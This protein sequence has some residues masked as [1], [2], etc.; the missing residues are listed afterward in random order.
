ML[1]T[2]YQ[3]VL[4]E[5][6]KVIKEGSTFFTM[7]EVDGDRRWTVSEVIG[8]FMNRRCWIVRELDEEV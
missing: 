3:G 1:L 6:S 4:V 5:V 7:K 2:R 8:K